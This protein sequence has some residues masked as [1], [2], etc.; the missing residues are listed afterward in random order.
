MAKTRTK[1]RAAKTVDRKPKPQSKKQSKSNPAGNESRPDTKA[2][3]VRA[4]L[5]RTSGATL[6]ELL[7]A[8]V[9]QPHS[10]RGFMSGTVRKR[11][12]LVLVSEPT[13]D[14]RRYRIEQADQQHVSS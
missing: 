7:A 3:T 14:G 11:M 6:A 5:K 1:N 12:G 10:V 13:T 4:L 8:T 2:G 9:W